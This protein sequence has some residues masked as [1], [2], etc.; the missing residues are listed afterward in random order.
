MIEFLSHWVSCTQNYCQGE[1]H[2]GTYIP[3][4]LFDRHTSY[5]KLY[6]FEKLCYTLRLS[7]RFIQSTEEGTLGFDTH[8][9][10]SS[11][12]QLFGYR[13]GKKLPLDDHT[14]GM[15]GSQSSAKLDH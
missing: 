1:K 15:D 10:V 9:T 3:I 5:I 14:E 6:R 4:Y 11:H 12:C 2:F 13:L 8:N 7:V